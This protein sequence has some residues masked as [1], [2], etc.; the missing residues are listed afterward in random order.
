MEENIVHS[1]LSSHSQIALSFRERFQE[2]SRKA[3]GTLLEV[4]E[5]HE[6]FQG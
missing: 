6:Q 3:F 2:F 1:T 5:K 4:C